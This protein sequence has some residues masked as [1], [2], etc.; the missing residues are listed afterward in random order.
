MNN[1]GEKKGLFYVLK[2]IFLICFF[3]FFWF[4]AFPQQFET[5][6]ADLISGAR[7]LQFGNILSTVKGPVLIA[8]SLGLSEIEGMQIQ[9]FTFPEAAGDAK[10]NKIF[11]G[12]NSNIYKDLYDSVTGIKLMCEGPNKIIYVVSNNNN[13]GYIN[14]NLNEGIMHAPFNFPTNE[15]L[16]KTITKV[17]IDGE[18]NMFVATNTDTIYSIPKA[19]ALFKPGTQNRLPSTFDIII[20]K[21]SNMVISRGAL[22]VKKI[23]LGV[24]VIPYSFAQS[25]DDPR[26]I[27]IG[28]NNGLYGYDKQSGQNINY[29]KDEKNSK[30]TITNIEENK[31]GSAIWFSTLEKGMGKFNVINKSLI[32]FEYPKK[33]IGNNQMYPIQ[34]FSRKSANEFFVAVSD[35][36][37]AVFNTETGTYSFINDSIFNETANS[38]T[39]IKPDALGNLYISKGGGFYWSKSWMQNNSAAFKIDS[40]LFGPFITDIMLNGLRYNSKY[41]FFGRSEALKEINLKYDENNIEIYYACRGIN[42]DSMV[43]AWKMDNFN[44]EW[45]IIPYSVFGDEV[46]KVYFPSLNPGTYTFR[47]K[48][49]SGGQPWLKN[50]VQLV[51]IIASPYWQKWWFWLSVVTSVSLVVYAVA[52][53]RIQVV[54]K[55]ERLKAKYE[56]EALELE[57]KALRSQMNPHFIFNCMN[58]MKSLIQ[59]REVDSAVNYLTTFSKLLRTVLYNCDKREITL[60]DEIETSLLYVQLESMRFD[61]KYTYTFDID[62]TIDTKSILVPALITQPFI[63]NAI[64]HGIMPK[65]GSGNLSV[66]LRKENES[67]ICVIDDNGIGREV[68]RQNKFKGEGATHQPKG[69]H[70]TQTRLDLDNLLNGRNASVEI[71]D[72]TDASGKPAGTT[73]IITF[74]EY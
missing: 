19:T 44:N 26:I 31:I 69:M 14:Y 28:T 74:K 25:T 63:E 73:V 49:K 1:I 21:D 42:K 60:H 64:W 66:S 48:A 23:G 30:F 45:Q 47:I 36:L 17:W 9:L 57:A 22:P 33:Q 40:S 62:K 29:L 67:I 4:A 70:L 72:K 39:D 2:R 6:P 37:P 27:L 52:K 59:R 41:E 3:L 5:I 38:T 18:G 13:F 11:F 24:G 7:K 61:N 15:L 68:S 54:R 53:W 55:Q 43:Y 71:M 20:D 12:K 51:V 58:S 32:F 16:V 35:S 10:G 56:K 8:N 46:N 65:E 50:E 34:T